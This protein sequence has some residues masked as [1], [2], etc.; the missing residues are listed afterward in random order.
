MNSRL[1]PEDFT[2]VKKALEKMEANK[3][4]RGHLSLFIAFIIFT[5]FLALFIFVLSALASGNLVIK[6]VER[7][8]IQIVKEEKTNKEKESSDDTPYTGNVS[9]GLTGGLG[10][11]IGIGL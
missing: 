1:S 10:G 2:A 4:K 3:H 9:G 8:E 5:V 11:G 7:P 6:E